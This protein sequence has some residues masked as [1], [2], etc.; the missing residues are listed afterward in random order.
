VS[1][2]VTTTKS[3]VLG[4][5]L[6][7]RSVVTSSAVCAACGALATHTAP[8]SSHWR[9]VHPATNPTGVQLQQ[10]PDPPVCDRHWEAFLHAETLAIG[11]CIECAAYGAL[12]TAS[13]CGQNFESF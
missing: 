2:M 9:R 5:D 4:I 1:E 7:R 8:F 13:P 10:V 6:D 12:K 3:F 11:W